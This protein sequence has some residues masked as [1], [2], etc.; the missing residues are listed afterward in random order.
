MLDAATAT[1][2]ALTDLFDGQ[3]K[4]LPKPVS[5]ALKLRRL[6]LGRLVEFLKTLEVELP[7]TIQEDLIKPRNKAIHG[8]AAPTVVQARKAIELATELVEQVSPR[9]NNFRFLKYS[10][11]LFYKTYTY[12]SNLLVKF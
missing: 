4:D 3:L 5:S 11:P 1:E 12:T 2:L 6:D 10:P 7:P 8:G 9:C